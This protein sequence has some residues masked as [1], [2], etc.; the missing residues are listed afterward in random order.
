[1]RALGRRCFQAGVRLAAV[2]RTS[3]R[4]GA[5]AAATAVFGGAVVEYS[6]AVMEAISSAAAA[7]AAA[8]TKKQNVRA[9]VTRPALGWR[10]PRSDSSPMK[11][12]S[13]KLLMAR[14]ANL[15]MRQG[16]PEEEQPLMPPPPLPSPPP[17]PLPPRPPSSLEPLL[18]AA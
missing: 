6:L 18:A 1:M 3:W 4:D 13:A 10:R 2:W 12:D 15:G 16:W 8:A 7:A 11:T 17:R 9:V 5:A 14:A